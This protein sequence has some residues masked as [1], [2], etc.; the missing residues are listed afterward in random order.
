MVNPLDYLYYKLAEFYLGLGF[1]SKPEN[2]QAGRLFVMLLVF[3][4]SSVGML[5]WDR[6]IG[7]SFIILAIPL[8]IFE[9]FYY[10]RKRV[11]KIEAKYSQESE[12][13][14]V[15][16]NIIVILY[17]LISLGSFLWCLFR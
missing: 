10:N 11:R 16:G 8:G 1:Q 15:N 12:D 17:V 2:T 5:I 3:N 14:R 4:I 7:V 13:S 6:T 9:S